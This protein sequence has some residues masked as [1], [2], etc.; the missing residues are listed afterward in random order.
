MDG[1]NLKTEKNKKK[2]N[3][4]LWKKGWIHS[5]PTP[6]RFFECVFRLWSAK[7]EIRPR[8]NWTEVNKKTKGTKKES[9]E[10]KREVFFL[11]AYFLPP[12]PLVFSFDLQ[13]SRGFIPNFRNPELKTHQKPS[14][15]HHLRFSPSLVSEMSVKFMIFSLF[16]WVSEICCL[17]TPYSAD[18]LVP[19]SPFSNRTI[20]DC[21]LLLKERIAC[22]SKTWWTWI[23]RSWR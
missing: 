12:F 14:T 8:E 13:L 7:N 4:L 2:Q 16:L 9:T 21:Y 10:R 23:K 17:L 19:F 22:A 20:I 15:I 11:S 5:Q 6:F 1:T 3:E 18:K